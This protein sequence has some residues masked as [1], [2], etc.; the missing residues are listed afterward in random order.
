MSWT[1][2]RSKTISSMGL[3]E[4]VSCPVW[5]SCC[6]RRWRVPPLSFAEGTQRE[7][8]GLAIGSCAALRRLR[9]SNLRIHL[10]RA[11]LSLGD[12]RNPRELS[13]STCPVGRP[14]WGS[15]ASEGVRG[16]G[17]WRGWKSLG[18]SSFGPQCEFRLQ[19][20]SHLL[21]SCLGGQPVSAGLGGA[22][23]SFAAFD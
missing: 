23:P 14:R 20:L 5:S 4:W 13:G 9:P 17:R 22:Q 19:T 2:A 15:T 11:G 1:T 16:E 6:G 8:C 3:A 10:S 18:R 21:C 7:R 12:Y